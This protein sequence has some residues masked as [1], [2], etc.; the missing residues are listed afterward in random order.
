MLGEEP[1]NVSYEPAPGKSRC[2]ERTC[3]SGKD[4]GGIAIPARQNIKAKDNQA[5]KNNSE[6]GVPFE[7][8]VLS[9][10]S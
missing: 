3:P 8:E 7:R 2:R 4:V 9:G 10:G 6:T 5:G 1:A